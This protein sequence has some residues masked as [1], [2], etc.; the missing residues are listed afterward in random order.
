M[1]HCCPQA[2][3]SGN[4]EI[5]WRRLEETAAS[6]SVRALVGEHRVAGGGATATENWACWISDVGFWVLVSDV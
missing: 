2:G 4:W 3:H 1:G 5:L 6:Q